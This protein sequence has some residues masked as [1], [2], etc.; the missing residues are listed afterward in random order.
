MGSAV[1]N[2]Q[3]SQDG[4]NIVGKRRV[5]I[6]RFSNHLAVNRNAVN[7]LLYIL[8]NINNIMFT[9]AADGIDDILGP[10]DLLFNQQLCISAAG[11]I[12]RVDQCS[13]CALNL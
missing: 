6:H 7:F 11:I 12:K 9:V 5:F 3:R 10:L 13:E 1:A 2:T 8:E 4:F